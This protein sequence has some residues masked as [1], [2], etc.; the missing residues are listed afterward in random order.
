M[1]P[2]NLG[3]CLP[4]Q[5]LWH[6]DYRKGSCLQFQKHECGVGFNQFISKQKCE[7]ACLK[8]FGQKQQMCL[9]TTSTGSCKP[10]GRAWYYDPTD[11]FCK[12]FNHGACGRGGNHFASEKKCLETCKPPGQQ[13]IVCSLPQSPG[14]CLFTLY[15]FYFEPKINSCL[16]IK[17]KSC[18]KNDNA[19]TSHQACMKRCSH[20]E[21]PKPCY[22]CHGI[23]NIQ[24]QKTYVQQTGGQQTKG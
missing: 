17:G 16:L 21:T 24:G 13:K 1:K 14:M 8:P 9:T 6:Y 11:G 4:L 18:G 22:G 23:K 2:P 5:N 12:M 19:F 15:R 20:P 3:N 7:E 10:T